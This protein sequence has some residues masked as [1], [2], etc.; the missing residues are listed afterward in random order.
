MYNYNDGL[1]VIGRGNITINGITAK[2]NYSGH[3][4][5]F[6]DNSAGTGAVTVLS[7]LGANNFIVI[8]LMV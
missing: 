2:W 7:T 4:G 8:L 1:Y 3:N 6:L 5:V